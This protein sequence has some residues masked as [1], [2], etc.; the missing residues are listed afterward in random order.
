[1][2][3]PYQ[4]ERQTWI[5]SSLGAVVEGREWKCHD[6]CDVGLLVVG[7]HRKNR[8]VMQLSEGLAHIG[9]AG[10]GGGDGSDSN[11]AN[12]APGAFLKR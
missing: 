10:V 7:G 11:G 8:N 1:M 9:S 4:R 5:D 12:V 2:Q 3:D 6:V